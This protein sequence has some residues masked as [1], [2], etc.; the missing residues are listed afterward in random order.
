MLESRIINTPQP[1][2]TVVYE[3]AASQASHSAF[4]QHFPRWTALF[5][6]PL[7]SLTACNQTNLTWNEEEDHRWAPLRVSGTTEPGFE[8]LSPDDTGINF[9]NVVT[10]DQL[11]E[12]SHYLNGSGLAAGD[13]DGDGWVDLYFAGMDGPNRLYRNLGGWKFE[14]IAAT[15]GVS[16]PERFSTGTAFADVDGDGDL[17]LFVNALGGPNTLYLNDGTGRFTDATDESGLASTM[18][19]MSLALADIDGDTDLDLYVVNNKVATVQDLF[20]PDSLRPSNLY[21]T[22]D[23]QLE[24][25]PEMRQHF[26]LGEIVGGFAERHERAEPDRLYLND[27]SGRFAQ[28]SFGDGTFTDPDG[29]PLAE[30]PHAWGLAA[31]FHDMDGDGD[32]DLYV[33]NDFQSPDHV[34]MNDGTGH[35]RALDPLSLRNTSFASMSVDFSDVDRDGDVDFFVA[36]ML[37]RDHSRRMRQLDGGEPRVPPPGTS[38]ERL[39]KN[40]NTLLTARGD[41]TW[42]EAALYAGLHASEWTWGTAFVDVDLDGFEDLLAGTGH[43]YDAMDK[44]AA[45][46]ASSVDWR[47][48]VLAF[49]SLRLPN[50]A[51]RNRGDLTF[52]ETGR[53]WGFAGEEDVTHGLVTA[54]LDNDG[55]LDVVTNRLLDVAG[56]YRNVGT[57][58]RVAVRLAGAGGNRFGVGARVRL[59]GGAVPVQDKEIAAGGGYLS[60]SQPHA[61]FAAGLEE[62]MI[63]VIWRSGTVTRIEGVQADRMYE[64]RETPSVG[65]PGN[66][67]GDPAPSPFFVDVSEQL[68]HRHTEDGFDD[69]AVQPLLPV[70]LGRSGPGVAWGDVDGDGD[71]D[72]V[73]GGSAGNGLSIYPNDGNGGFGRPL[74]GV[75]RSSGD[76]TGI[77]VIPRDSGADVL[78]GTAVYGAS[79]D[80]PP[81]GLLLRLSPAS[82]AA[83]IGVRTVGELPG[84]ESSSGPLAAADYD[85]DGNLDLFVGGRVIPGAYPVPASSHL[86]RYEDGEFV[87]DSESSLAFEDVGMVSGA[88]F[89]DVDAD[90]DPDLAIAVEWGPIRLFLNAEGRFTETGP[91]WGL[92]GQTGWWNGVSTADLNEDGFPDLIATNRGLNTEHRATSERPAI[93]YH[94]DFDGN[95]T[96]DVLEARFDAGLRGMVPIRGLGTLVTGLPLLRGSVTGFDHFSTLRAGELLGRPLEGLP[97]VSANTLEHMVYMSRG[98][99]AFDPQPLPLEAQLSP[100]FHVGVADMDGDGHDDIFLGQNLF[101]LPHRMERASAG[102]GLWLRGDG[103]GGLEPVLGDRSGVTVHGEQKGAALSDYDGDGRVDLVVTQ[104]AGETRLFRNQ[105]AQVGLRVR[106]VGPPGNPAGIGGGIRVR[107]EDG[108]GPLREIRAGGGYWSQ[109]D[110][111]QVMGLSAPPIAL[112]VRC[113]GGAERVVQLPATTQREITVDACVSPPSGP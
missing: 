40:R 64:I 33:C 9:E 15:A 89:S 12:N 51:F 81:S 6:L 10:E 97:A 16:A 85:G 46:R 3:T 73:V 25:V 28:V 41:G 5:L 105:G 94:G 7:S 57:A 106:L 22:V 109:D 4:L 104:N 23:G 30:E 70:A 66:P 35:F 18:G 56:V 36:E 75:G 71:A 2:V 19:S 52:E 50:V 84:T 77:V 112:V 82:T 20:P 37:S 27:G 55:D 93:A 91:E 92:A 11:V 110:P 101:A 87:L 1:P 29:Q 96:Y 31:R 74:A 88:V 107:Y 100:A 78:V 99:T 86:Y 102:R 67:D 24:I 48:R 90:G 69:L 53:Q 54:D 42:A 39:Q 26:E 61:T 59:L 34:W 49:P 43:Y 76:Q 8:R 113:P 13:I 95:G 14:E 38:L 21:R 111:V 65:G 83:G 98:G 80:T 108:D 32:P 60:S 79:G 17:D 44:D 47:R 68:G 72:L 63:E 58:P 62:M 45:R 103:R